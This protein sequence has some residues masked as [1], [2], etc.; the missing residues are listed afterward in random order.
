MG[1]Y[2]EIELPLIPIILRA[3]TKG[4]LID[5]SFLKKLT[6]LGWHVLIFNTHRRIQT[7]SEFTAIA[8][9]LA[10]ELNVRIF[11]GNALFL[12]IAFSL[13]K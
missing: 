13:N 3:E 2:A 10:K 5:V 1:V 6:H 8:I 9:K 4:V 12:G 7:N 11:D